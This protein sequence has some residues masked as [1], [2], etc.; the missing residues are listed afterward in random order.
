LRETL[1]AKFEVTGSLRFLSHQEMMRVWH[2]ALIR[3]CVPISFSEGF[4]PHPRISLPL[5]RSVGL[6]AA[7]ELAC[8]CIERPDDEPLDSG[9]LRM[10]I[11]EQLPLGC[12]LREVELHGGKASFHAEGAAYF[13]PVMPSEKLRTAVDALLSR[14]AAPERI[15]VQ[16]RVN[17]RGNSRVVDVGEYIQSIEI[18][19][20]GVLAQCRISPAGSIRVDEIMSLLQ[21]DVSML[22]GAVARRAVQWLKKN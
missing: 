16:R 2:R 13:L 12:M 8:V 17:D 19:D 4:N 3:A 20:D 6:A 7:G 18:K 22:T 15:T 1:I 21:I 10:S 5:P 9:R 11:S 14:L